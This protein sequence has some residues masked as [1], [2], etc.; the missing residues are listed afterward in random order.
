MFY[1]GE[2]NVRS[3]KSPLTLPSSVSLKSRLSMKDLRA[4]IIQMRKQIE[5]ESD[6]QTRTEYAL[7]YDL[8]TQFN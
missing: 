4:L 8:C 2:F 5:F 7:S 6:G 3:V 1:R